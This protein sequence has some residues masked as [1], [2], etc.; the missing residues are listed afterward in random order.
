MKL[1]RIGLLTLLCAVLLVGLSSPVTAQSTGRL[2]RLVLAGPPG[3]L[4][5]PLAYVVVNDR[6]ADVADEVELVLWEDQNQLRA[7][8]AGVQA[9]FVTLPSNNAAI[10]YNNGLD[11]QLLNI[12]AWTASFGVSADDSITSLSDAAGKRV[13]I[14][15]EGSIPDLLFQYIASAN[16]FDSA[17]NFEIQ[18]TPN[19]QQA[20]Q[21]ILSGQADVAI[22]PEP[23]A[24]AVLLATAKAEAP[25]QRVFNLSEEWAA[26]TDESVRTPLTG[27]VALPSVQGQPDVIDA[28][29]REYALAVEWVVEHPEE[30][31]QLA[32]DYLP[33]LG[34][35]A[36]PVA[37]SLQ[38]TFWDDVPAAEAREDIESFFT[39]LSEL[40]P[41]VIGGSLPDDGFYY[42]SP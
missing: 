14:P 9:D 40:S 3:P 6:L 11:M 4:S 12:A 27:T 33:E 21:L 1:S 35:A 31:G 32:E 13:V 24:T 25:L 34:L 42:E 16:G 8:V 18:Y 17:E 19:P 37:R 22:L 15:F 36:E 5:I 2:E 29:L 39:L 41:D 7:I 23:L 28:F 26:A 10:F 20:A 30:A 38:Q